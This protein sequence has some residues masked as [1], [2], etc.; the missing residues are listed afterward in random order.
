MVI[1]TIRIRCC[2]SQLDLFLIPSMPMQRYVLPILVLSQPK[3]KALVYECHKREKKLNRYAVS[4]SFL[5][6]VPFFKWL[7]LRRCDLTGFSFA[8][9]FILSERSYF[10]VFDVCYSELI[11]LIEFSHA[12]CWTNKRNGTMTLYYKFSESTTVLIH[13]EAN[14]IIVE[15]AGSLFD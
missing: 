8:S 6:T 1:E 14:F 13:F 2:V 9:Y 7:I 4:D 12:F 10:G 11:Q 5:N 3:K 15:Y